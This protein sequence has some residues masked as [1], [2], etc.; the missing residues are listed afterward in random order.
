MFENS[1]FQVIII[2]LG[3]TEILLKVIYHVFYRVLGAVIRY[4]YGVIIY[5]YNRYTANTLAAFFESNK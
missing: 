3:A 5:D 2:I 1:G 4:F